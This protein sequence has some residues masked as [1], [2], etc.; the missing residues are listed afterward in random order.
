[1]TDSVP[2]RQ[3]NSS[4]STRRV[5]PQACGWNKE[6][7]ELRPSRQ[8]QQNKNKKFPSC[9]FDEAIIQRL[10][11]SALPAFYRSSARIPCGRNNGALLT[12]IAGFLLHG[13]D[14]TVFVSQEELLELGHFAPQQGDFALRKGGEESLKHL[15]GENTFIIS[16][17]RQA[18]GD[19]R[20]ETGS[21]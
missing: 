14:G 4:Q 9:Y 3:L 7:E 19:L 21:F 1:M 17:F 18:S 13:G 5:F 8:R 20:L 10:F 15:A 11:P 2:P 16:D 6:R 12:V